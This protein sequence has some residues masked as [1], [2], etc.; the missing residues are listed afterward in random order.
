MKLS[1]NCLLLLCFDL[2]LVLQQVFLS[3]SSPCSPGPHSPPLP[4][5]PSSSS[6]SP[7]PFPVKADCFHANG[8]LGA[9]PLSH[10]I[11]RSET[12]TDSQDRVCASLCSLFRR[13]TSRQKVEYSRD[14]FL[15]VKGKR[16][17]KQAVFRSFDVIRLSLY[18][19]RV[20]QENT[21]ALNHIPTY[22]LKVRLLKGK[23]PVVG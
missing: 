5:H 6:S 11:R 22:S 3:T 4:P 13:P 17:M 8:G 19:V 12:G 16:R 1:A 9:T 21:T 14:R 18:T 7:P 2:S 10:C 15:H 23:R 20:C